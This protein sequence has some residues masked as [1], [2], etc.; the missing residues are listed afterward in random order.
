MGWQFKKCPFI[1]LFNKIPPPPGGLL[2]DIPF[3]PNCPR[4]KNCFVLSA[5]VLSCLNSSITDCWKEATHRQE[6][7]SLSDKH[8]DARKHKPLLLHA[9]RLLWRVWLVR[10]QFCRHPLGPSWHCRCRCVGGSDR[11]T[12]PLPCQS[13]HRPAYA[14]LHPCFHR[15][16]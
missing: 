14:H 12:G 1:L 5:S 4:V 2:E 7:I 13:P 16:T 15:N 9:G 11:E 3:I 10:P 8:I 6:I